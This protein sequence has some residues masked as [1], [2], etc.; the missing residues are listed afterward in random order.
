MRILIAVILLLIVGCTGVVHANQQATE[1]EDRIA[2]LGERV[3]QLEE[4][5]IVHEEHI[6]ALQWTDEAWVIQVVQNRMLERTI[7]CYVYRCFS[8]DWVL[9]AWW[10]QIAPLPVRYWNTAISRVLGGLSKA[11]SND[12][13]W[14]AEPVNETQWVVTLQFNDGTAYH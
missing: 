5:A 13:G 2:H 10:H 8:Q 6:R 12:A 7:D 14:S 3:S 11:A 9:A 1:D 4:E